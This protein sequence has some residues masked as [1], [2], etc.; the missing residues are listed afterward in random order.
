MNSPKKDMEL[1]ID[2]IRGQLSPRERSSMAKKIAKDPAMRELAAILSDMKDESRNSDWAKMR[3][4]SH[5]LFDQL[6]KDIKAR[7]RD[8]ANKRGITVFDSKYL[9]LP[10]GVRSEAVDTRR[11][12]YMIG[13]YL[14][15][16]S[17]YP[18]SP[19]SYEIIGQ[20]S[21]YKS[22]KALTIKLQKGKLVLKSGANQFHLFRFPRVS[23]GTYR[24]TIL[25][26]RT[27]IG[28]IDL[29]L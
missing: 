5:R 12:K 27:S 24:L 10:E 15:E 11:I 2:Y 13:P 25:E 7:K 6:F 9:P 4:P 16:I 8:S 3:N 17:T 21:D 1:L 20:I 28:K 23:S 19:D 18:V 14:L 26:G 29:E 22:E